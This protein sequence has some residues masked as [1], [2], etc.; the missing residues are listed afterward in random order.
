MCSE[1]GHREPVREVPDR[2]RVPLES[3]RMADHV[4]EN[5]KWR[6]PLN[7]EDR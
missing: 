5:S 6:F 7:W 2:D 4:M 3:A 1:T